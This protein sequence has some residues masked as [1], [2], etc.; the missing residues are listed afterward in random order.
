MEYQILAPGIW[1][2]KN[3]I[4][5]SEELID[6]IEAYVTNGGLEWYSARISNDNTDASLET[7]VRDTYSIGIRFD[8]PSVP[9]IDSTPEANIS[10]LFTTAF[11][12]GIRHYCNTYG[13]S[14]SWSDDYQI[15]KYGIG[16]KFDKHIDDH[17]KYPRR[18]SLSYYLNDNYE[19][20]EIEFDNFNLKIKPEKDQLILFPSNYVYSHRVWP[21]TSGTRYAVVQWMR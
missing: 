16:Q 15:L 6:E 12:D 9:A 1:S 11:M 2:F 5:Y 7:N 19:G 20:G 3:V 18:L 4:P 14:I 13:L 8:V 21:V 17:E 10:R